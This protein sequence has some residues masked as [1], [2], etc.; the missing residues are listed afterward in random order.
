MWKNFNPCKMNLILIF[1]LLQAVL[2]VNTVFGSHLNSSAYNDDDFEVAEDEWRVKEL[3]YKTDSPKVPCDCVPTIEIP[4]NSLNQVSPN[5]VA[6]VLEEDA[7]EIT[8][9]WI[10]NYLMPIFKAGKM[11]PKHVIQKVHIIVM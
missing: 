9:E 5:S 3:E 6:E 11:I 4:F 8:K 2:K 1:L 7:F 10:E